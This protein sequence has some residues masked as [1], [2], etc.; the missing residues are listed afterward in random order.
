MMACL[1]AAFEPRGGQVIEVAWDD[2]QADWAGYDAAIIGTTWDYADRLP[3]F[4]AVLEAI[5][6]KTRLFN[7]SSLVR[8][9]GRKTYLRELGDKGVR[10][11]PTL[12]AD[13][14]TLQTVADAFETF[15]ADDL[16]L[17]RQVGAGAEGQHRLT[18]GDIVPAMPHAM[19]IQPFLP[20]IVAEGELS[21]IFIGGVFSHA[22]V[23]KAADGD[24]RIQAIYGGRETVY[25]AT[26]DDIAAA[27]NVLGA[28]PEAPLYARVD[29][30]RDES[31]A[32]CLMEIELIEPYLYPLQGPGLGERLYQ[33]LVK[34]IS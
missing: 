34:A 11:I 5:E 19:M 8:W 22:L 18:R 20:A 33:A 27:A 13:S 16:I 28:C 21:F 4:L 32:L 14:V 9:N 26:P 12:W 24:Y 3:E 17:K 31:G 23:K 30:L 10:L 6:S 15:Q 1:R 25:P 2:A 7:S 29:M